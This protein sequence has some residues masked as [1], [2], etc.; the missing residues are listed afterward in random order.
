[1]IRVVVFLLGLALMGLALLFAA[2]PR[3]VERGWFGWHWLYSLGLLMALAAHG[4]PDNL[5]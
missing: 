1:M 2:F 3:P 4:W 5:R